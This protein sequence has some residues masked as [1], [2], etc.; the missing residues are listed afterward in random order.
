MSA[1]TTLAAPTWDGAPPPVGRRAVVVAPHPD[2]EVLGTGVLLRWLRS[3]GVATTVLAVTDGE[4]SHRWSRCTTPDELRTVRAAERRRALT[5][6]GVAPAIERLGLP[7]GAVVEH[8]DALARV[9]EAAVDDAT[10]L[11]APWRHDGH[12][13]HDAT[14]RA[15]ARA[16]RRRGAALW[17]VAIWA[18]VRDGGAARDGARALHPDPETQAAREAAA[19]CFRSQLHPLGPHPEDGPVVH[20]HEL[21]AMLAGPELVRVG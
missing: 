10:T 11:I 5:V 6:L 13:D 16:A 21:A 15:A 19:A 12:P 4:A 9:I 7:D 18:A 20:P 2:D 1:P 3:E 14:G 17:E 8:E